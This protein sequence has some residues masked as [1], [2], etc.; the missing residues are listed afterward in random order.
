MLDPYPPTNTGSRDDTDATGVEVEGVGECI[1]YA[2]YF[3]LFFWF[4]NIKQQ[5]GISTLY[6]CVFIYS[7]HQFWGW[8]QTQVDVGK[9][10][11]TFVNGASSSS[12]CRRYDMTFGHAYNTLRCHCGNW[13]PSL[14]VIQGTGFSWPKTV[15]DGVVT[16]YKFRF[17][18]I[19]FD[20]MWS[21]D[22]AN[23]FRM[24]QSAIH[25][26]MQSCVWREELGSRDRCS[27][28][29]LVKSYLLIAAQLPA[30][31]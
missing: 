10:R 9:A 17:D 19:F 16:P 18:M 30:L 6:R 28:T 3:K 23:Q 21:E 25:W 27:V 12:R 24:T 8:E 31:L 14:V 20:P 11:Q 22:L 13:S 5:N 1:R 29:P 15:H 7:F 4:P 26:A 2:R